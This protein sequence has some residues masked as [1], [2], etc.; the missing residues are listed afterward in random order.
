MII[1]SANENIKKLLKR[2]LKR[3]LNIYDYF[4]CSSLAGVISAGFTIPI[5]NIR[6]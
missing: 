5:D 6:T 3:E 2:S 1:V 4:A